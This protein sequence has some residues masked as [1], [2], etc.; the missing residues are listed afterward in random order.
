RAP[1]KG[2]GETPQTKRPHSAPDPCWGA[3]CPANG[4]GE[5]PS[6]RGQPGPWAPADLAAPPPL[7]VTASRTGLPDRKPAARQAERVQT[8]HARK[9]R[10]SRPRPWSAGSGDTRLLANKRTPRELG[11]ERSNFIASTTE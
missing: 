10:P 9:T 6:A 7:R 2:Q 3:W 8:R 1:R 5:L 4:A 11:S